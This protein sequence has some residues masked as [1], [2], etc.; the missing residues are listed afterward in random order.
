MAVYYIVWA[1][2]LL[3]LA[4]AIFSFLAET[5][6]RAAQTCFVTTILAFLLAAVVL[7]ARLTHAQ[8]PPFISLIPF[9]QLTPTENTQFAARFAAEIGVLVDSLSA[10]FAFAVTLVLAVVQGYALTSLRSEAG[11]RRFFWASS[12]L[13]AAM[14]GLVY[15]PNLF[16][17][18]LMWSL[19]SAAVYAIAAF[20]WNRADAAAPARRAFIT[21]QVADVALLLALVFVVDK[22]GVYSATVP[23]PPGQPAADPLGFD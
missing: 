6:R 5:Q 9:F 22:F 11:L 4:G 17:T 8:Q 13:A 23:A 12:V 15:S 16:Q 2:V 10:T 19:A 18:L 20:W 1:I 7:G 14:V 3:P 21:T